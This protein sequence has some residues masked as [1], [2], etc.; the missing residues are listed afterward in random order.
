MDGELFLLTKK[1]SETSYY[2]VFQKL[3]SD[4]SSSWRLPLIIS[5]VTVQSFIYHILSL[6]LSACFCNGDLCLVD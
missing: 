6:Y 2:I 3:S 4:V 5:L 1:S